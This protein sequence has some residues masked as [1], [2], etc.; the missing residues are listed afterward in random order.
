MFL[1]VL[2]GGTARWVSGREGRCAV[3]HA[4]VGASSDGRLRIDGSRTGSTHFHRR[5]EM[6]PEV[7]SGRHS[8][9]MSFCES[10]SDDKPVVFLELYLGSQFK[11]RAIYCE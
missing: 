4:R 11:G 7:Q 8:H 10:G 9:L 1:E 6:A 2:D 3:P 5:K